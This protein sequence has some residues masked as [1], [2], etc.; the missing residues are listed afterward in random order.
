M[1]TGILRAE[2]KQ[3]IREILEDFGATTEEEF[4]ALEPDSGIYED[5]KAGVLVEG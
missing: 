4:M 5:L 3:A 2:I 1:I